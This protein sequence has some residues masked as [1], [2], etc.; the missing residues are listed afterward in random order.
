MYIE[1]DPNIRGMKDA[2]L[3]T[4]E[5]APHLTKK[6]ATS[7]RGTYKFSSHP[8]DTMV[9]HL[10]IKYTEAPEMLLCLGKLSML[11]PKYIRHKS[12]PIDYPP[13]NE[14][15]PKFHLMHGNSGIE[16]GK[17][18]FLGGGG[19]FESPA[20]PPRQE[21]KQAFATR[22][23]SACTVKTSYGQERLY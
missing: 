21:V 20:S 3:Q 16:A 22:I 9:S 17:S 15:R 19:L 10:V 5:K 1:H 23:T 4:N 14:T 8:P 18:I 12:F 2:R 6:K 11:T 13:G 7:T